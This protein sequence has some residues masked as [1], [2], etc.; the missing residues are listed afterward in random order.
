MR[1][2]RA[3]APQLLE[4][5]KASLRYLLRQDPHTLADEEAKRQKLMA[6]LRD[7]IEAADPPK[8]DE[9]RTSVKLQMTHGTWACLREVL[10]KRAN[11]NRDD[12]V[13]LGA[14][15][16]SFRET[17]QRVFLVLGINHAVLRRLAFVLRHT[18]RPSQDK[19]FKRLADEI[20]ERG[21][22]KNPMEILAEMGL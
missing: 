3:S 21:L 10:E 1:K 15:M 12:K 11:E 22:T 18:A 19:P 9:A 6:I 8:F 20:E 5:T 4:A 2:V 14:V 13:V 17:K 16:E 7:A